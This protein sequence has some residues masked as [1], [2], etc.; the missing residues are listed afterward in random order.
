MNYRETFDALDD[1]SKLLHRA[2]RRLVLDNQRMQALLDAIP[3]TEQPKGSGFVG[4][5]RFPHPGFYT[6]N[7]KRGQWLRD[8]LAW[9][10]ERH[11]GLS[12]RP[13]DE[14]AQ[15]APSAPPGEKSPHS[16]S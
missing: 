9:Q 14:I 5:A 1:M 3:A 12:A 13:G 11:Q 8:I 16:P 2:A 7:D 10:Q 6:P 4:F 15:D